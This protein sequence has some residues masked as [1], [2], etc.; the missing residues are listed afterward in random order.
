MCQAASLSLSANQSELH[1]VHRYIPT[2]VLVLPTEFL[3]EEQTIDR[4]HQQKGSTKPERRF[5]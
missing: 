1:A 3:P 4:N 5:R 2:Q